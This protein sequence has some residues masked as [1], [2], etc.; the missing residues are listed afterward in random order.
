MEKK[1]KKIGDSISKTTSR[2]PKSPL[3]SLVDNSIY[4]DAAWEKRNHI[5]VPW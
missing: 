5:P 3:P 1:E 2:I 4:S